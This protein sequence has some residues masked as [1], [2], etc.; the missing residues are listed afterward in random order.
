MSK[1]ELKVDDVVVFSNETEPVP[2]E[3]VEAPVAPVEEAPMAETPV[4][5]VKVE[6]PVAPENNG[7][8]FKE[9]SPRKNEKEGRLRQMWLKKT[10]H[11]RA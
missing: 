5:P 4:E 3:P 9:R 6:E 10:F 7:Y 2:A 1:I 11:E 8:R